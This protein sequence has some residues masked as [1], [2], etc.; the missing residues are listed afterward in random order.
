MCIQFILLTIL[1]KCV[2]QNICDRLLP[3]KILVIRETEEIMQ[4]AI[5]HDIPLSTFQC[6]RNSNFIGLKLF[7]VGLYFYT[8]TGAIS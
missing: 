8:V 5:N 3:V 4:R 1:S 6:I 7:S 2:L